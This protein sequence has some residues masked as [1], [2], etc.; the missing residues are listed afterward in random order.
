MKRKTPWVLFLISIFIST[1]AVLGAKPNKNTQASGS[2]S[3]INE[4]KYTKEECQVIS[5]CKE[6]SFMDTKQFKECG[7]T[8]YI[9][10]R[11]CLR[12]NTNNRDDR[13]NY[14]LY[15]PCFTG[16]L[17]INFTY[18]F[19]L[20]CFLFLIFFIVSL[21]KYRDQLQNLLYEKVSERV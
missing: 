6:C 20:N 19:A 16:G 15:K 10:I 8:G 3:L 4:I 14:F 17:N 2:S 7:F 5:E 11:K 1:A 21:N 12:I 18:V 9:S 13:F